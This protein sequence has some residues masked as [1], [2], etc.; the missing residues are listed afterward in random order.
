MMKVEEDTMQSQF[1][2]FNR[3]IIKSSQFTYDFWKASGSKLIEIQH[4]DFERL[5]DAENS[6]HVSFANK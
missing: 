1:I 3:R 2:T 4:N 6:L 5:E